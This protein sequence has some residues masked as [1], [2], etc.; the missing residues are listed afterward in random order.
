MDAV[1]HERRKEVL[2]NHADLRGQPFLFD[3]V[4]EALSHRLNVSHELVS[5]ADLRLR[6]G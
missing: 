3:R 4:D 5:I 1:E 2:F 6:L